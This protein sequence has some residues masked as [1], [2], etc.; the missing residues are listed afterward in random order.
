[1]GPAASVPVRCVLTSPRKRIG[2]EHINV[3]AD[4]EQFRRRVY[5][6]GA[7]GGQ[8]SAAR[9]VQ[10][11]SWSTMVTSGKSSAIIENHRVSLVS[12]LPLI[13]AGSSARAVAST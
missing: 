6:E 5:C 1:M 13:P 12:G 9:P 2:V 7:A 10:V 8:S 4:G 3:S 11:S